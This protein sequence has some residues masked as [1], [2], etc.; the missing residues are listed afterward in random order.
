VQEILYIAGYMYNQ[1][2]TIEQF[3]LDYAEYKKSQ[4]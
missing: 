2:N 3:L 4:F 1:I